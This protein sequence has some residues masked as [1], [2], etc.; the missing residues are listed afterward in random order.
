[1]KI[2]I[3]MNYNILFVSNDAYFDLLDVCLKSILHRCNMDY[4]KTIYIADIG[5][6][7]KNKELLC[8]LHEKIKIF[9][10]DNTIHN[11]KNYKIHSEAWCSAVSQKTQSLLHLIKNN[12]F[13]LVMMDTDMIV[14][15]DFSDIIDCNY[16]I[17]VCERNNPLTRSDG[18]IMNYIASFFCVNSINGISFVEN[19]IKRITE[20]IAEKTE[21]PYETPAMIDIISRQDDSIKIGFVKDDI[22]SCDNNYIPNIT[23]IIH[24]KSLKSGYKTQIHRFLQCKNIPFIKIV[25]LLERKKT[26]FLYYIFLRKIKKLLWKLNASIN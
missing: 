20:R 11:T 25:C 23:R 26:I 4:M 15:K 8:S 22:V 14:I 10:I 17:Q 5:L 13:P 3:S 21:P 2:K 16:D 9:D 12:N 1:M 7:P 18:M 24:F 19:W 6:S